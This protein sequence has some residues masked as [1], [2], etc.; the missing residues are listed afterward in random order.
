MKKIFSIFK[1]PY[2][3]P[4]FIISIILL[5]IMIFIIPKYS[6]E[7]Q[8]N[9][10]EKKAIDIVN[11]LKKIRAYYTEYII[12]DLKNHPEI[13]INFDHKIKDNTIP[14]PATLLHDFTE[15]LAEEN[16]EIKLYSEYPFENRKDRVLN[17]FQKESLSYLI[18]N[19]TE[20]YSKIIQTSMGK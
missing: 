4:I 7:N 8:K 10:M 3:G 12:K 18:N 15:L 17:D 13:N 9:I 16:M 1:D 6:Y 11:N 20:I 5:V 19:P 14:L 2:I